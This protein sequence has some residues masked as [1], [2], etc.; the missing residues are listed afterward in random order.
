MQT[1]NGNLF[2]ADLVGS[3]RQAMHLGTPAENAEL[4]KQPGE[5]MRMEV[6]EAGGASTLYKVVAVSVVQ[7]VKQA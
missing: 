1:R 3:T 7:G 5:H 2:I 4:R 6:I